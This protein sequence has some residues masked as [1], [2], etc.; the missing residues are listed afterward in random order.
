MQAR[1][2][3]RNGLGNANIASHGPRVK[4]KERVKR[5]M[6]NPKDS[7]K[8]PKVPKDL[9]KEKTAKTGISILENLKLETGSE[10]QE[11][12]R[13]GHVCTTDTS[14]IHDE[15]NPDEWNDGWS[16]D[17]RSDDWSSLGGHEDCEQTY[18]TGSRVVRRDLHG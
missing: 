2:Q 15:W 6:E 16:L 9:A 8:D 14:W 18:A 11:T 12:A 10:N 1:T 17:E 5:T 3:A 7:R 4:A 13:M